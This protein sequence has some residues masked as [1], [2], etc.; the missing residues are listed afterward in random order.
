MSIQ[1]KFFSVP[2]NDEA[3]TE[4]ELNGFLR[5]IRL[6]TVHR[7]LIS[8]EGR[9]YW[10]IA[11]E[12]AT[13]AGKD[14]RKSIAARKRIDYKDELSPEDFAIFV[15]LRD[16]RKEIAGQEAVAL[17]TVFT[18]DQLATMIEKKITSKTKLREINGIGDARVEKYGDSVVSILKKVFES[19]GKKNETGK[20]F[21]SV[22]SDT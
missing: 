4:A 16:W 8:Q 18:N 13:G 1:Y 20:K 14:P 5:T 3:D 17:Y 12:Y 2:V 21:I 10:A 9:S 11:V 22:D 19:P 7:E 15:K 6:I